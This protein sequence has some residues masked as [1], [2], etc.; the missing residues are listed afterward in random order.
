MAACGARFSQLS[1]FICVVF[2]YSTI[3]VDALAFSVA[4][5]RS[6]SELDVAATRPPRNKQLLAKKGHSAKPHIYFLFMAT[7]ELPT[8]QLWVNFFASAKKGPEYSAFVHCVNSTLCE[9]SIVNKD[10][11]TLIPTVRSEWCFDLVSPMDALL[12]AA[13]SSGKGSKGDKFVFVSD[14]TVPVKP[15][16]AVQESLVGN[17]DESSNFCIPSQFWWAWHQEDTIAVKH[18]QWMVLSRAHATTIVARRKD[19]RD[20]LD[21]L[22]PLHWL[23]TVH[24]APK[25]HWTARHVGLPHVPFAQGCL[26]EYLYFALLNGFLTEGE[27]DK[28]SYKTNVTGHTLLTAGNMSKDLQGRCDTFASFGMDGTNFT[29]LI[30]AFSEDNETE[31]TGPGQGLWGPL[32]PVRFNRLSE[33]SLAVL[34]QSPFLFARKITAATNYSGPGTLTEAFNE[35]IFSKC[36]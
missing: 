20:L 6:G 16:C 21:Q 26:D 24:V 19:Q 13:L 35:H 3:Y 32:H 5:P 1:C 22:T 23:G 11:F 30:T 15:F 2:Y 29:E 36:S 25:I 7:Q 27:Y 33:K 28:G 17:G 4:T 34:R 18:H 12:D 31:V 14:S 9:S 8:E 10:T